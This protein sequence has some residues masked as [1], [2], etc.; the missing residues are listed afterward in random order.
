[1]TDVKQP[2]ASACGLRDDIRYDRT[3]ASDLVVGH[4]LPC[5]TIHSLLRAAAFH[6]GRVRVLT[7]D[8]EGCVLDCVLI[9]CDWHGNYCM[10]PQA[11]LD[12]SRHGRVRQG[13]RLGLHVVHSPV[14]RH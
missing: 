4:L 1:M 12:H 11:R 7:V 3:S 2:R 13:A 9:A 14:T 5:L 10:Q 8:A 6:P